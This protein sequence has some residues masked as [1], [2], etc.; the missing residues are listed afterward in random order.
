VLF[1]IAVGC[2]IGVALL[3]VECNVYVAIF[4]L[5]LLT[6]EREVTEANHVPIPLCPPHIP[7]GGCGMNFYERGKFVECKSTA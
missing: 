3:A 5:I 4:V 7:N 6:D 1:Y 2:Q